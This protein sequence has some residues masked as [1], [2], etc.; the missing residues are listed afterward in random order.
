MVLFVQPHSS[1]LLLLGQP[2][3]ST[4]TLADRDIVSTAGLLILVCLHPERV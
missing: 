4:A 3:L 1:L 2:A